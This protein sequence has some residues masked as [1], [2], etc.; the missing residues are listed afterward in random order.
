MKKFLICDNDND[1]LELLN[2]YLKSKGYDFML[3]NQ[4]NMVM[5]TLKRNHIQLV[6]LDLNLADMHGTE[7]IEQIRKDPQTKDTT[8]ILLTA[9]LRAKRNMDKMNVDGFVEKPFDLKDLDR[10]IR[11]K[12]KK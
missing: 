5:E 12:L 4:G 9:S 1:L 8:I 2:I 7:I 11:K 6:F 3:V 10:M